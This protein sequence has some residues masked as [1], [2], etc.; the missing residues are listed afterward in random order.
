MTTRRRGSRTTSMVTSVVNAASGQRRNGLP[1]LTCTTMTGSAAWR[2]A[3]ARRQSPHAAAS[4]GDDHLIDVGIVG[5]DRRRGW[6]DEIGDMSIRKALTQPAHGR[7]REHDVS[8][9]AQANKE[10]AVNVVIWWFGDLVM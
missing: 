7:R 10:D 4:P 5:D 6:F 3:L 2:P 8:N 9:L 1:A